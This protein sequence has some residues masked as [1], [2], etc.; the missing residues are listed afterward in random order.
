MEFDFKDYFYNIY[1]STQKLLFVNSTKLKLSC[2][3]KPEIRVFS[4]SIDK[5]RSLSFLAQ[6]AMRRLTVRER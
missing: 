5:I 3:Y 2:Y 6:S 4:T 1:R